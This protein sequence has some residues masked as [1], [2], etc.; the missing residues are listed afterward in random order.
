M[1]EEKFQ[2]RLTRER[3]ARKEAEQL[4]EVKSL[5]LW[6]LNQ[7]LESEVSIRTQELETALKESQIAMKAKGDF[8]S[9]MSH[10]IRTPLNAIIGFVD[11][12]AK[13]NYDK[14]KFDKYL[15]IIQTSSYNLLTIIND[16]LDYSKIQSGKLTISKVNVDVSVF[17]M[18]VFELFS[19]KA[20]E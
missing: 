3:N 17:M 4:L 10:E 11:I 8:L 12:M 18:G 5:E 6:Q 14:T 13:M 20:K 9:N 15:N 16:I 1:D 19:S 7:D 2:R